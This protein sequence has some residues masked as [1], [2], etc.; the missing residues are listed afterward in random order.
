MSDNNTAQV[1]RILKP[2][3]KPKREKAIAPSHHDD[4]R[5]S[6]FVDGV[7]LAYH[8]NEAWRI[9]LQSNEAEPRLFQSGLDALTTVKRFDGTLRAKAVDEAELAAIS[10]D[11]TWWC[12][13][14]NSG[15]SIISAEPPRGVVRHMAR[16]V[17]DGLPVLRT[18]TTSPIINSDGGI[19]AS[20]YDNVSRVYVGYT[21]GELPPVA[22]NPT[23]EH[24]A[25]ALKW[26]DELLIDFPFADTASR[27]HAI[28]LALSPLM[29]NFTGLAPLFVLE[30]PEKGSGKTLLA[31][32]LISLTTGTAVNNTHWQLS[33]QEEE[34]RK[35]IGTILEKLPQVV[36]FDNATELVGNSLA[37]V[38]SENQYG[39]RR[40][41][42]HGDIDAPNHAVWLATANNATMSTDIVRRVVLVRLNANCARPAERTGFQRTQVQLERWVMQ[43]R[44]NF[45]WAA[46]TLIRAGLA[47]VDDVTPPK[48]GGFEGW[49]RVC[50][51]ICAAAELPNFMGNRT[52]VQDNSDAESD[53]L[54]FL[55]AWWEDK[56]NEGDTIT[57]GLPAKELVELAKEA[58]YLEATKDVSSLSKMLQFNRQRIFRLNE[59]DEF[60]A[61][62]GY[63]DVRIDYRKASRNI[64]QW[65]LAE[66][67]PK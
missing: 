41:G 47:I 14:G 38:L 54:P 21:G 18:L 51:A 39:D 16:R 26:F 2:D 32:V 50:A 42:V 66:V 34:R 8:S 60:G 5:E 31:D 17:P 67:T 63:T 46:F 13:Y 36:M 19:V 33:A 56:R 20:G 23:G 44:H 15:T 24:I 22:S 35:L 40:L 4:G 43:E 48:V 65:Y 64:K 45:L 12:K 11:C 37:K 52:D 30:A 29:R 6:L 3:E 61:V 58:E 59:V 27:T 49:A 9:I 1:L 10:A 55:A 7:D 25:A 28:L 62:V 53:I 57:K